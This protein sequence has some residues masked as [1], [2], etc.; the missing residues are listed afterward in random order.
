[1]KRNLTHALESW[2]RNGFRAIGQ[3]TISPTTQGGYE[4]CHTDDLGK[5]ELEAYTSAEDAR[6]LS[7]FDDANAYRPLKTAPTLKHGWRLKLN[8]GE[9]LRH[10]LDYFYP[11]MAALWHSHLQTNLP[12]VP[13]RDTLN[14]QTGMYAATKRLQDEEGQELV[15]QACAASACAKRVLWAFSEGQALTR[16]T[17]E[18]L[19]ADPRPTPGGLQE[20]P[21]LCHEACNILVAACREVVKKRERAQSTPPQ[22]HPG[23]SGH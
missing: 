9:E 11:A 6:A 18:K 8:T 1:L 19:S 21:L 2:I 4:L 3:I 20:I 10:A 7:F 22:Q 15:G 16:L 23:S 5:V 17:P 14:R 13:L 12:A